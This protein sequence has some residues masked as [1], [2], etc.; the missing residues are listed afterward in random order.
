MTDACLL[1]FQ[2]PAETPQ[3]PQAIYSCIAQKDVNALWLET[4]HSTVALMN[5]EGLCE[6]SYKLYLCLFNSMV[7]AFL[8]TV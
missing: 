1:C 2:G 8:I 7:F 4:A 6:M 5:P 3:P